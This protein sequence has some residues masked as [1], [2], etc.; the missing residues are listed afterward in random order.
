LGWHWVTSQH[1]KR[2]IYG[3]AMKKWSSFRVDSPTAITHQ[4]SHAIGGHREQPDRQCML[5]CPA[6]AADSGSKTRAIFLLAAKTAPYNVYAAPFYDYAGFGNAFSVGGSGA[7]KENVQ[8]F[9]YSP[10]TAVHGMA[11]DP[12][13]TF[14][15]S[16]D[17]WAN[18]IWCHRKDESGLLS[19]V[20]S[21]E[22]PKKG[23]HPR[24]A[25]MHPSG[26][27]LYVLMEAG[28]TLEMYTV[29][30]THMPVH[31]N[32]SYPLVPP[33]QLL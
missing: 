21:I 14:L 2:N 15:Y 30:E 32:E 1:S 28:N 3:S 6:K 22:A 23:D 26:K 20:G 16:A 17:M 33:C 29:N 25:A 24:W 7:L 8:N 4:S 19:L 13:E 31:A 10:A 27:H 12:S 9:E 11:F 18:K 5:T